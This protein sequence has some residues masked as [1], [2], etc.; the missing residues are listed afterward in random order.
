MRNEKAK[1]NR[2]FVFIFQLQYMDMYVFIRSS[3]LILKVF[4]L[5]Y[6]A[7]SVLVHHTPSFLCS[8]QCVLVV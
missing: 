5:Q 4:Y 3:L 1:R 2:N 7:C 6:N 8:L